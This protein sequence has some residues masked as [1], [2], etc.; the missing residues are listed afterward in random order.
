M[1]NYSLKRNLSINLSAIL[2]TGSQLFAQENIETTLLDNITVSEEAYSNYQNEGKVNINR[3]NIDIEDTAKSIQVFN[4]NFIQ[5]S[6]AQSLEDIITMSSNVAYQGNKQG[7]EN[8]F[9][10][11]GFSGVPILRDGLSF[12]NSVSDAEI[13]NLE[14]VEIL[15]GPD[16][17]QYGQS[18]PG[19]IVNLVKKKPQK[20]SHA[21]IELEVTSNNSVSPKI[22]IGGALNEDKSLRYRLVSTFKYDE[23][24]KDYNKNTNRVF[25]SPSIAKDINDNHTITFFTE[26]LD[27]TKPSEFGAYLKSDGTLA[28][29]IETVYTHPDEE[30]K[31]TQKIAGFDIDSTFDTW[32]SNFRYRYVDYTIDNPTVHIPLSYNQ[33]NNTIS[34]FFATQ[35]NDYEE[36]ALQYTLNKE[37]DI[38]NLK[39]RISI[40]LDGNKSYNTFTGYMDRSKIYTLNLSNPVYETLT[41]LADHPNAIT[42]GNSGEKIAT[43]KWGTFIQDYIDLTDNLV[44]SAA[45]RYS[46]VKPDSSE[47]SS[48]ITPSFGLVYKI[49]PE[50]SLYTNYS[51]SFTP[52]T[53]TDV[54]GKILDPETGKGIELG[55]K[56]K[57]FDNKFDL[58][59]ALFKI[60]KENIALTDPDNPLSY[61]ASGK[62][63]SQGFEIDLSGDI[64]S[65]WSVITSYGYAETEDKDNDNKE[66]TGVPKHTANLFTTYYLSA[67]KLPNTYI[68]AGA[69]YLGERYVN[70][71]NTIKL[72]S[73]I[74][75]SAMVGYKKGHWRTN[76]S[77]QNLTDEVYV[78]SASTVRVNTGTPRTVLATVSYMF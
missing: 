19:G 41:T 51:E 4:K 17:L 54:N 72:D 76:L 16:S 70:T 40:G 73:D 62:Q 66:L 31:K 18:S 15:K 43:E 32:N 60:E 55:I 7:R 10:I 12:S 21:Q 29:P 63:E 56:Q 30:L 2:L 45:A 61:I 34:R 52:N 9:S 36:H 5:D 65:N 68:G 47:K 8:I 25:I 64:T 14:S 67:F 50:T 59:S 74:I 22:D 78:Q 46:Q 71:A 13:Y 69:K 48:A 35:R 26:Y 33:T 6:Q 77:I 58:T 24:Y 27:E 28:A 53:S 1:K 39:N 44:L 3:T 49:T 75:Y 42:Y 23:G 57:L 37:L 20:E 38:F 11:R